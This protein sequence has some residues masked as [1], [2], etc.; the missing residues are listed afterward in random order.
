[1]EN[2]EEKSVQLAKKIIE[3][4]IRRDELLEELMV[5]T[6]SA[7]LELLRDLQNR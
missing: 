1:M 2:T 7:A 5:L 6:G 3:L 4:D